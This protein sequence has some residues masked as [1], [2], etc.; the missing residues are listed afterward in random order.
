[1]TPP[2]ALTISVTR[3]W[4]SALLFSLACS[5]ANAQPQVS[6]NGNLG[7]QAALLVIE[8]Q[9]KSVR[10]GQTVMGVRLVETSEGRAVVDVAGQRRVLTL[11]ATQVDQGQLSLSGPTRIVLREGSDGHFYAQGSVNGQPV[12]FMV[13]TGATTIA[14]DEGMAQRMGINFRLGQATQV[15]TANGVVKGHKVLLARVQ[16]GDVTVTGVEA[17]VLPMPMPVAL[18]G[19]SFLSRFK[20]KKDSNTLT[21]DRAY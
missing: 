18:L 14:L 11:G 1:M 15:G 20:M 9:P 13:D 4:L 16:V 6:L 5:G 7:P 21:L 8:G 2:S 17:I 3:T 19:N 10:V 12:N